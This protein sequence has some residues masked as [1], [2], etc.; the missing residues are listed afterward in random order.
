MFN[1]IRYNID[2]AFHCFAYKLLSGPKLIKSLCVPLSTTDPFS[3]TTILSANRPDAHRLV[4]RR[5]AAPVVRSAVM[6][7]AS[8][9]SL[10]SDVASSSSR[11][12]PIMHLATLLEDDWLSFPDI[13]C[14]RTFVSI[15]LDHSDGESGKAGG[16]RGE[17]FK[18]SSFALTTVDSFEGSRGRTLLPS[19]V[20][21]MATPIAFLSLV[22]IRAPTVIGS[23]SKISSNEH[24]LIN[25]AQS[26]TVRAS[27]NDTPTRRCNWARSHFAKSTPAIFI[28]PLT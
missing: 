27:F 20:I 15:T 28:E 12:D 2:K 1:F 13:N 14:A 26:D 18:S 4:V 11:I 6:K 22:P 24:P 21:F 10:M 25:D 3:R 9:T 8:S 17:G 7:F 19:P 16:R 23:G 5:A